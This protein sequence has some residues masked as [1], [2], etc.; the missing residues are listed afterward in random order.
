MWLLVALPGLGHAA[1]YAVYNSLNGFVLDGATS[2]SASASADGGTTV[3][4]V[5]LGQGSLKLRAAQ[6]T[7]GASTEGDVRFG[8]TITVIGLTAPATVTMQLHVEGML[9]GRAVA[10]SSLFIGGPGLDLV[11][12][13][14][15]TVDFASKAYGG[16]LESPLLVDDLLQV[17]MLLSPGAPT[18]SFAAGL[19]VIAHGPVT[20]G[21]AGSSAD[22]SNTATISLVLPTGTTFSA[23][24]GVLLQAV[25]L[26]ASAWLLAPALGVLVRRGRRAA[27]GRA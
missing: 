7:V 5:D 25:P 14:A 20:A 2:V 18:F 9:S 16:V 17:S 21:G 13:P 19:A 23:A 8:D 3:E 11:G 27:T 10:V 6:V 24:S 1:Q 22:F 4:A 26:P 12:A 15:P